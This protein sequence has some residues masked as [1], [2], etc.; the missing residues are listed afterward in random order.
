MKDSLGKHVSSAKQLPVLSTY[1]AEL[2]DLGDPFLYIMS[3]ANSQE[4]ESILTFVS[5]EGMAEVVME[6]NSVEGEKACGITRPA[7]FAER[8]FFESR[9]ISNSRRR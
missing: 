9:A 1:A 2:D 7:A 3:G 4:L 8:H 6:E 5:S